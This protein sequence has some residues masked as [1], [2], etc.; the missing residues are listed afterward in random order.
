MSSTP[1]LDRALERLA[2]ESSLSRLLHL[3][4]RELTELFDASRA[5]ISRTIGDLLVELS[6]FDPGGAQ[7]PLELFLVTDY[8]LTQEVIETREPRVV[9][10][11]TPDADPAESALLARLGFASLVMFPLRSRGQN[12]GLVEVWGDGGGFPAE[13]IGQGSVLVERI[14]E[15]LAVLEART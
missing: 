8:P 7:P 1:E 12:W 3:A 5:S 13:R 10:A 6:H 2:A 4:C 15:L 11:G 9:V 14:G